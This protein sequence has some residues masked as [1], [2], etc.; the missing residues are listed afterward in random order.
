[1][2]LFMKK[3]YLFKND[4]NI[5]PLSRWELTFLR[6]KIIFLRKFNSPFLKRDERFMKHTNRYLS[7]CYYSRAYRISF[8]SIQKIVFSPHADHY[9]R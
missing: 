3:N 9:C 6:K 5:V 4:T 7:K 1:M 8:Y 2:Q